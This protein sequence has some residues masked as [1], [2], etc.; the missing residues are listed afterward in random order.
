V[1]SIVLGQ[2]MQVAYLA[3][4]AAHE[5]FAVSESLVLKIEAPDAICTIGVE[6]DESA[7]ERKRSTRRQS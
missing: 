3:S 7:K 2:D 5:N 4:D 6:G 1:G